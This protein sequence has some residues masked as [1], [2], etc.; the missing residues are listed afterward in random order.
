MQESTWRDCQKLPEADR[1][2]NSY[3]PAI[4]FESYTRNQ[5]MIL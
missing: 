5:I 4:L 1:V 3:L 2:T